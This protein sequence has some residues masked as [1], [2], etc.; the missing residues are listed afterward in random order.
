EPKAAV[1]RWAAQLAPGG[2][3][4][5]EDTE[6]IETA[7]PAFAEYVARVSDQ[8]ERRGQRLAT[9][10]TLAGLADASRVVTAAPAASLA[11]AMFR[12]NLGSW[13]ADADVRERLGRALE[14]LQGDERVGL[15]TWRI[16]QAVVEP[17]AA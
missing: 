11:A 4:L 12:L 9:G 13:C 15:I 7:H 8:L 14:A 17:P 3:L 5:L 16:R 10:P 1:A 2:R 6:S